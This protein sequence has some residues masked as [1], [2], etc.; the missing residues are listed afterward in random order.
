VRG[1]VAAANHH[2]AHD[3]AIIR[4]VVPPEALCLAVAFLLFVGLLF[5]ALLYYTVRYLNDRNLPPAAQQACA[6]C[7]LPLPASSNRCPSC[8]RDSPPPQS[9]V[10]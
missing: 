4:A 3:S 1:R 2:P 10:K 6:A 9:R 8:G 5:L 7:G